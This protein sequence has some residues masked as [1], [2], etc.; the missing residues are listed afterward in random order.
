MLKVLIPAVAALGL[1][2][3][4]ARTQT[5]DIAAAE[6]PAVMGWHVSH[7]G[8]MAK[9]AYGVENSD[10]LALMITCEPGDRAAVVYGDVQPVGARLTQASL[11]PRAA[12]PLSGGATDEARIGLD[13]PTLHRLAQAGMIRVSGEAGA[14]DIRATGDERRAIADVLAYCATGR[15]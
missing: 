1:V 9:V 11:T 4:A 6:T 15:A 14:F 8:A 3:F 2:A 12:D 5:V 7:E 13:D 10:Q